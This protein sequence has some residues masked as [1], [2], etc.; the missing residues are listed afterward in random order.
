MMEQIQSDFYALFTFTWMMTLLHIIMIDV[1][2][3]WD[4]AIIIGMA[5]R[6]LPEKL[7]KKAIFIGIVWATILRI[8]FAFF[9]VFLLQVIGIQVAGALLLLYVVW[10]FYTEL[11]GQHGGDKESSGKS[12]SFYEAVK[13][14]IIAD[15][16]MSL[17]NVLAVAGA[18]KENVVAL[19]IGL[20]ISI[21]L[22]A[23][24]SHFIA[25]KMEEYPQIQ[26]LWL[27]VI[28]LVSIEMLL[29]G[30]IKVDQSLNLSFGTVNL[31][32]ILLFLAF[33]FSYKKIKHM[34]LPEV[35]FLE[36]WKYGNIFFIPFLLWISLLSVLSFLHIIDISR[37]V[38]ILY[39]VFIMTIIFWIEY[40]WTL[41]KKKKTYT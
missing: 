38:H 33:L 17:D 13:L 16:S 7:K 4:N 24:A 12:Q 21:L 14:I 10:K 27:V 2:L 37:N 31:I 36:K 30:F 1:V 29:N 6:K 32:G 28:L 8:I 15:V 39:S 11:R 5:T 34:S 3:S 20:V 18:A 40:L 19:G 25:K 26:W 22:M 23:F 35:H 9:A 41:R